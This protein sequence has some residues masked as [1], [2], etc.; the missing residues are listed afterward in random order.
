MATLNITGALRKLS[1][2]ERGLNTL[3]GRLPTVMA[4]EAQAMGLLALDT[5]VYKTPQAPGAPP[6]TGRLRAEFSATPSPRGAT[7][8]SGAPYASKIEVI[9]PRLVG[10]TARTGRVTGLGPWQPS[11]AGPPKYGRT[12]LRPYLP[13]PHVSPAAMRALWAARRE[14]KALIKK[15]K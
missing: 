13:G 4:R 6:R 7:I 8:R 5:S 3:Q 14:L 10:F 15:E 9:D 12:G 1:R 2:L 11:Q